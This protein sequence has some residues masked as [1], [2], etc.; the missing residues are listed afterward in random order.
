MLFLYEK[1]TFEVPPLF[2]ERIERELSAAIGEKFPAA[3]LER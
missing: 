1:K 2:V 3:V